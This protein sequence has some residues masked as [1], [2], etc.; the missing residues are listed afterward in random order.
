ML[1]W[2]SMCYIAT[3]ATFTFETTL[4]LGYA[5]YTKDLN[6]VLCPPESGIWLNSVQVSICSSFIFS[7]CTVLPTNYNSVQRIILSG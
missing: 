2:V 5:Y 3:M 6:Y 7:S 4:L 1:H